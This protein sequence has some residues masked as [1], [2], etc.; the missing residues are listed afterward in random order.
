MKKGKIIPNGVSLE[1]HESETVV[2]FT[3]LGYEVELIPP[4]R[5]SGT[6]SPDFIMDLLAWEMKSPQSN[7]SRTIEHAV[8]SASQQSENIII[9]LR[10]SKLDTDRAIAQIQF[11]SSKRTNIK[12]LIAITKNGTRLDIK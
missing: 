3:E 2:F 6:K 4:A 7:G 11:H 12:R 9:D 10:R 1:R 5:V 8:R